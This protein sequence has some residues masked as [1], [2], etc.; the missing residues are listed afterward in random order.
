M[1]TAIILFTPVFSKKDAY[2]LTPRFIV[3][4]LF[5]GNRTT[6]TIDI[7]ESQQSC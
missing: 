5:H 4:S 1:E 3:L 7:M 2:I 6:H